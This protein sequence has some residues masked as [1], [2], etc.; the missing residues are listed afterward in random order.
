MKLNGDQWACAIRPNRA[1]WAEQAATLEIPAHIEEDTPQG[2]ADRAAFHAEAELFREEFASL[3]IQLGA[4]YDGSPIISG[5]GSVP[6]PDDPKI[7]IPSSVPG[8]RLPHWWIDER[9]SLFD[10]M[11]KGFT[12]LRLRPDAPKTGDLERAASARGMPFATVE[13]DEPGFLELCET[14]LILVRPDQHV[15]WRG[16]QP[17]TDP[18]GLLDIVTRSVVPSKP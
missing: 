10:R 6:P 1:I 9:E 17:P 7:Y 16:D 12:L 15:A 3:G 2:D 11:G 18:E 13:L 8:G 14:A 4:R 5:D